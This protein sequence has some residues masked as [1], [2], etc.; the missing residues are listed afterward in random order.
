MSVELTD[1]I[2]DLLVKL[3]NS[4]NDRCRI[5][6]SFSDKER[7]IVNEWILKI[8]EQIESQQKCLPNCN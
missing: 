3:A 5:H 8:G 6:I 1:P 4:L 2:S 7:K